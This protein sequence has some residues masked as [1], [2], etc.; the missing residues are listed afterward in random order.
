ME[1]TDGTLDDVVGKIEEMRGKLAAS[2]K[3]GK[4]FNR[5]LSGMA[6]KMGISA[7]YA[8]TMAGKFTS[9]FSAMA[10]S[11]SGKTF[12]LMSASLMNMVSP[13]NIAGMVLDKM[14]NSA[15]EL[16]KVSKEFQKTSG[17]ASDMSGAIVA[18]RRE[19]AAMG[20]T[21]GD[22]GKSITAL[23]DN[24]RGINQLSSTQ[25]K[26]LTRNAAVLEKYG[27]STGTS[28][29]MQKDF[30]K[31]LK[32]TD[33]EATHMTSR[34]AKNAGAVGVSAS[35][36]AE[37]FQASFGYLALYGDQS[38]EVFENLAAQAANA[39]IEISKMLDITKDFDKFSSGAEKAARMNAV[40]GTNIS[41]MAMMTMD[42]GKRM[43]YLTEQVQNSVGSVDALT[44]AQKLSL[45][46]SMG[47]SNVAEMMAA[48][49]SNTEEAVKM[50]EKMRLQGNIEED[51]ANALKDLLP[52]MEQ[53]T[54]EFE[55]LAANRKVILAITNGIKFMVDI[56]TLAIE[57]LPVLTG[58]VG[59]YMVFTQY[60]AASTMEL[61]MAQNFAYGKIGL[62]AAAMV[63]LVTILTQENSPPLYLIFGVI[64]VGV[65]F[66]GR[67]LDTMGPKAIVGALALALLAGAISLI[68]YGISAMVESVTG[69]FTVLIDGVD[70]LPTVVGGLIALGF[71][72]VFLGNMASFSAVGILMG[73]GALTAML[74]LFKAT[75]TSMAD[76]FGIGDEVL[77]IGSGIERFASGIAS[78]RT[79]AAEISSAM[80]DSM[81]AASMEGAKMSVV[82][83]K[84]AGIATLFKNDTLN[85]KVD[86][87]EIKMP[88]PN[89]VIEIDGEVIS[90]KVRQVRTGAL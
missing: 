6:D 76:M 90:A 83:G 11:D 56:V 69:L 55:R 46:E 70:A 31:S 10:G 77:K 59:T 62:M 37:D 45:T 40:F 67:A 63:Y 75:G 38:V 51:M 86:M 35:K 25:I 78:L 42:A 52:F 20:V 47:F 60:A 29:K 72:F 39:G 82:V 85:I 15:L 81:I 14:I 24:F 50:K 21:I 57:Y 58:I 2:E 16:D 49:G 8:D 18:N 22:V 9:M 13:L 41:S 27:V 73:V 84:Q 66:F 65:L 12:E 28:T 71:A 87:P 19:F 89:F 3:L 68:F 64:A 79:A 4:E 88:T 5:S 30:M 23:R 43:E 54:A 33:T 74:L 53:I 32:M 17:G 34:L 26:N 36:M 7:K 80:G 48:L 1:D 44:H 61:G